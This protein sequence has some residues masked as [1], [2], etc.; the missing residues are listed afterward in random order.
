MELKNM[1]MIDILKKI[2]GL[3]IA[4]VSDGADKQNQILREELPFQVQEYKS[5]REHNGWVVPQKWEVLRAQIKKD[6]ELIYDGQKH[7][8]GVI[9]Y[10]K[11][12]S[13]KISLAELK[14]HLFYKKDAPDDIVYHCDLY[15]KPFRNLWGFSMP[16]SIFSKLEEGEYEVDLETKHSGHTMKVLEYTHKGELDETIILNAHNCHAAQL[17][18]GPSGYV[19]AI[20][21]MKALKDR[22]TRYTYKLIIAPEHLGTVFYLADLKLDKLYTY[23]FCVFLDMLG[24]DYPNFALQESFAGGTELDLAGHHYLK[25]KNPGYYWGKFRE[26]VG[27]DETVW[28]AAGIEIPTISLS[29][30]QSSDFYY[31]Q[32]HLSS[33]NIEIIKEDKLEEGVEAV[34]GIIDILEKNYYLR[35]KFTGLVALSSPKYN[36]YINTN[37]PSIPAAV[38][39]NQLKWNYLMDC[40]PRYFDEKISILDIARKHELPFSQVYDYLL[41][42][43][44][45]GLVDFVQRDKIKSGQAGEIAGKRI[46]LRELVLDDATAEYCSWLNDP[47]VNKYLETRQAAIEDLKAFIQKQIDNPNSFFVGIFDKSNDKHIGNIKLEPIDW[48]KKKAALGIL[49]GNKEY[50]GKGIGTE[51][52][53]LMIDYAFNRL[54]LNEIGLGV[55]SENM[56]ARKMYERVGFEVVEVKKNAIDHDGKLYDDVI[57]AIKK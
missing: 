35:R 53:K 47:A 38:S 22:K 26:V 13:G 25:F 21:A 52:T 28:E 20:E 19:V 29:R 46:Y 55:I 39:E 48:D 5:G 44:E 10:S 2:N 56:P 15:Y 11:S 23:K 17:N 31:P 1:K 42:F 40:L 41:K 6:G 32:Y 51:A 9:G 3:F 24:N 33:D 34:L 14:E 12:F 36:L 30:C 45:N 50:W 54:G 16:Y 27:N 49:I 43:K 57:M 8:L 18:D 37:D 7:P 4:P